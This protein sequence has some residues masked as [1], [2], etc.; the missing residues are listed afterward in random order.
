MPWLKAKL[1]TCGGLIN[2]DFLDVNNTEK[3]KKQNNPAI[4]AT[5]RPWNAQPLIA[6][7]IV[8]LAVL[9]FTDRQ[10]VSC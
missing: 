5:L 10:S 6:I 7:A 9:T 2:P 1:G 3:G 8:I 4:L